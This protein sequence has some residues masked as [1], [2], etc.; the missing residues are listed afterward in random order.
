M[1]RWFLLLALAAYISWVRSFGALILGDR[2]FTVRPQVDFA[3]LLTVAVHGIGACWLGWTRFAPSPQVGLGWALVQAEKH[4]RK[5]GV[6]AS[7]GAIISASWLLIRPNSAP[8]GGLVGWPVWGLVAF[9]LSFQ[10]GILLAEAAVID[11]RVKLG[12]RLSESPGIGEREV[13]LDLT[14][15]LE[16]ELGQI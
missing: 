6:F 7:W 16:S 12:R 1:N 15:E 2:I 14:P 3:V 13:E 10:A 8:E 4:R 9:N 5:G 11:A